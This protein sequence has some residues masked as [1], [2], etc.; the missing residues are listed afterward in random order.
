MT[1][2]HALLLVCALSCLMMGCAPS[3]EEASSRA[4]VTRYLSGSVEDEGFAR[5]TAAPEIVFPRD[6]GPHPDYRIEWWYITGNV[7]SNEA[8]RFGYEICFFRIAT[9]P[10]A[11]GESPASAWAARDLFMV[12]FGLSDEQE[13]RHRSRER[14]ER[15][16]LGLA[17]ARAE[18]FEVWAGDWRLASIGEA[19]APLKLSIED[20]DIELELQLEPSKPVVLQG[21]GGF[22]RKGPEPGN[23]SGYYSFTRLATKGK[24]RIAGVEHSVVGNSW[25]DHE[26]STSVLGKGVVGWDWFAL[27]LDDSS[28]LMVYGLR[29]EDGGFSPFSHGSF[30]PAEGEKQALAAGDFVFEA[31]EHWTSDKSGARYPSGWRLRVPSLGFDLRVDPLFPNQE[32]DVSVTY[33]EGAVEVRGQRGASALT[34]RG[35]VELV[36]YGAREE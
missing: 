16:A 28:E 33:W 34:G 21:E 8:R 29:L 31:L 1:L 23:A 4:D 6:H 18:P 35:Y 15:G 26:W 22:S 27:Q 2:Q 11:R 13:L 20:E 10:E 36:G 3:A 7:E 5:M 19:F 17:G 14:F 32:M 30:V 24:L 25:M 12:H 9:K